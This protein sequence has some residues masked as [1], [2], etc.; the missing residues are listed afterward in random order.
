MSSFSFKNVVFYIQVL[1]NLICVRNFGKDTCICLKNKS[2]LFQNCNVCLFFKYIQKNWELAFQKIHT[3]TLVWHN[4][5]SQTMQFLKQCTYTSLYKLTIIKH[6][7]CYNFCKP[8]IESLNICFSISS[9]KT[10]KNFL[11]DIFSQI[12]VSHTEKCRII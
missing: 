9:Y 1:V 7:C 6:N 2:R 3:G 10:V 5:V 4:D 12:L 8:V 11:Y